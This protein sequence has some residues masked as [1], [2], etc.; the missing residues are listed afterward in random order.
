MARDG[1]IDP[2]RSTQTIEWYCQGSDRP[3][4]A[5]IQIKDL[6]V[7]SWNRTF[8]IDLINLVVE[9]SEADREIRARVEDALHR[10]N[11][12]GTLAG[13]CSGRGPG[14]FIS[15]YV[16]GGKRSAEETFRIYLK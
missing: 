5:V 11:R 14:L 16:R 10:L 15:G 4:A 8:D 13:Q 7:P 3:S 2:R 1:M 9:G 6:G 12:V